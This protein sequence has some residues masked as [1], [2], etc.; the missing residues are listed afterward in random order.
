MLNNLVHF[1]S[2][3]N[4]GSVWWFDHGQAYF[5]EEIW[6]YEFLFWKNSTPIIARHR[7]H[8]NCHNIKTWASAL[9]SKPRAPRPLEK[10]WVKSASNELTICLT[11]NNDRP[12]PAHA[13]GYSQMMGRPGSTRSPAQKILV[14]FMMF[15]KFFLHLDDLHFEKLSCYCKR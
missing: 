3:K 14:R 10:W 9:I 7:H 6:S 11:N 12:L 4:L 8:P 5:E 15:F 1:R 2:I 13:Q